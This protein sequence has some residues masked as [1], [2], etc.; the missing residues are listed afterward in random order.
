MKRLMKR[1]FSF[2][3]VANMLIGVLP[4][5]TS[6][7]ASKP[8]LNNKQLPIYVGKTAKIKMKKGDKKAKV[9]WKTSKKTIVKIVKKTGKGSSA[10]ATVKGVKSGTATIT[11]TYKLNKKVTK[12]NC[13]VTVKPVN[14]TITPGT[15]QTTTVNNIVTPTDSGNSNTYTPTSAPSHA[16]THAATGK[17]TENPTESPEPTSEPTKVPEEDKEDPVDPSTLDVYKL[18]SDTSITI[19][20]IASPTEAW[21][22]IDEINILSENSVR[23]NTNITGATMKLMWSATDLYILVDVKKTGRSEERRVGKEC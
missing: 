21:E 18:P 19:D 14:V 11:A 6:Q 9:T 5:S 17:P 8:S 13:K 22:Y 3:L 2:F 15:N 7:A 10:Y 12:L 20:G 23:G 4:A 1:C 16:P